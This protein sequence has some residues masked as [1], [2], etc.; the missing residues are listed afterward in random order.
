MG[1][2]PK[3][4]VMMVAATDDTYIRQ[5]LTPFLK[6][7]RV[8][9][10]VVMLSEKHYFN[11]REIEPDRTEGILDE[12]SCQEPNGQKL[13]VIKREYSSNVFTRNEAMKQFKQSNMILVFEPHEIIL[14]KMLNKLMD[15]IDVNPRQ[16]YEMMCRIYWKSLKYQIQPDWRHIVC[17]SRNTQFDPGSFGEGRLVWQQ[18]PFRVTLP[19]SI[20]YHNLGFVLSDQA[21][22]ERSRRLSFDPLWYSFTWAQWTE[23][24]RNLHPHSPTS[25]KCAVAS[26]DILDLKLYLKKFQEKPKKK[27]ETKAIDAKIEKNYRNKPIVN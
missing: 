6:S 27:I 2:E 10:I 4:G 24:M 14:P 19:E 18:N 21:M 11:G 15:W 1:D 16:V 25:W 3:F 7:K 8:E 23:E 12:L 5:S 13:K 26:G 9:E 17:V 22:F 20:Y